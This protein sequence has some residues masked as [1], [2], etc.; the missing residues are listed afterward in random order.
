MNY[1]KDVAK[2]LGVEIGEKFKLKNPRIDK[3][4]DSVIYKLTQ[5]GLIE[6]SL[7]VT[8]K[9]YVANTLQEILYGKFEIVKLPKPILTDKEKK[10]LSL[11]IEPWKNE[12]KY[13]VKIDCDDMEYIMIVF[14]DLIEMPFPHF[15]KGKYYKGM[16]WDKEY[17]LEELGL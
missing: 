14:N 4:F 10:Y 17:S 7:N 15:K 11:I 16:E 3:T 1:M 2:L 12:I 8:E 13:M 9:R 6:Y 5:E